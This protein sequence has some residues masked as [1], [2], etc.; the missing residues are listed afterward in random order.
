MATVGVSIKIINWRSPCPLPIRVACAVEPITRIIN[1]EPAAKVIVFRFPS[2]MIV[3]KRV[4]GHGVAGDNAS[5]VRHLN[6]N[7]NIIEMGVV[8]EGWIHRQARIADRAAR[9]SP[10]DNQT[11]RNISAVHGYFDAVGV[12]ATSRT[13]GERENV[14]SL[15]QG[16]TIRVKTRDNKKGL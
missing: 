2:E 16:R 1:K 9:R 13:G 7:I 4:V 10:P 12:N 6:T 11:S 8:D 14:G 5:E 15:K 3:G